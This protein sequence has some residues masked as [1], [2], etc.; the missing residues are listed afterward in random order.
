MK[1]DVWFTRLDGQLYV[2]VAEP[3]EPPFS[4]KRAASV[5]RVFQVLKAKGKTVATVG[6]APPEMIGL[7]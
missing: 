6:I 1:C 2:S 3:D 4:T 7:E 5:A